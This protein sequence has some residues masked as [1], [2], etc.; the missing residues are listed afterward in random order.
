[1]NE[2]DRAVRRLR[3][4]KWAGVNPHPLPSRH[5]RLH[6]PQHGRQDQNRL[7]QRLRG[8]GIPPDLAIH[9]AIHMADRQG[10]MTDQYIMTAIM[11]N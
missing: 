8:R 7:A 2:N 1:M 11:T 5:R 6:H 4:L 10:V 3:I 9:H